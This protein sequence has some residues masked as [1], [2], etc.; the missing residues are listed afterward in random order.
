MKG[1]T[2]MRRA[3]HLRWLGLSVLL[4]SAC[5]SPFP[6]SGGNPGGGNPGG[7]GGVDPN[8]ERLK[9]AGGRDLTEFWE[10]LDVPGSANAKLLAFDM[11][12]S[13]VARATAGLS[14]S[15]AGVDQWERNRAAFGGADY[16][17]SYVEDITPSQQKIVLWR[18]MAYQVCLDAVTRDAGKPTRLV[19]T[20]VDPAAAIAA[21]DS[22][23]ASQ[24]R[25]LYERVFLDAPTA[26]EVDES[27]ALLSAAYADG[28]DAKESWRALC[29]GY[30]GSMKF[31][32]Y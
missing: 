4:L 30:L 14:W 17:T 28:A 2:I 10:T 15:I 32:T 18:K 31:L 1:M 5:L 26:L 16:Q 25:S 24:V 22:A 3:K 6:P 27:T 23:V 7:G 12:K 8:D 13:E 29:V 19:F 11:M 20:D 21:G 9:G